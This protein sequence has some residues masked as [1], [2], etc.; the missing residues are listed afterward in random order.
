MGVFFPFFKFQGLLFVLDFA[1]WVLKALIICELKVYT[2]G[3]VKISPTEFP[4]TDSKAAFFSKPFLTTA[5]EDPSC[6]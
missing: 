2:G 3:R 6:S 5:E 4:S 1:Y